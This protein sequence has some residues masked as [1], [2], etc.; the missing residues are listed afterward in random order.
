MKVGV[1]VDGIAGGRLAEAARRLAGRR[2]ASPGAF[3]ARTRDGAA[4]G[5]E[6]G[7]GTEVPKVGRAGAVKSEGEV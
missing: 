1:R 2:F 4:A 5:S 3:G 7:T 6:T